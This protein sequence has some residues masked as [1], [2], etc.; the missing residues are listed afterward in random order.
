MFLIAGLSFM[1]GGLRG[2]ARDLFARLFEVIQ[3]KVSV[4]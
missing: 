2:L 3:V 4:A 1:A